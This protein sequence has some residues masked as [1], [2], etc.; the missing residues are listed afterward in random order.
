MTVLLANLADSQAQSVQ[1]TSPLTRHAQAQ[2][3]ATGVPGA[4]VVMDRP[5]GWDFMTV[6]VTGIP[7]SK[8]PYVSA[9]E[10]CP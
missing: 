3:G 4:S 5:R 2:Y 7:A 6:D 8:P 9:S 1:R 10:R